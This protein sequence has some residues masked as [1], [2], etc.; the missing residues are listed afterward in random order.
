MTDAYWF[1]KHLIPQ[2]EGSSWYLQTNSMFWS[3]N[4]TLKFFWV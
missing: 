4:K 3:V 2:E 1:T